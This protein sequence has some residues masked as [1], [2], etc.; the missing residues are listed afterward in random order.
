MISTYSN[1]QSLVLWQREHTYMYIVYTCTHSLQARYGDNYHWF[2]TLESLPTVTTNL[3]LWYPYFGQYPSPHLL[4]YHILPLHRLLQ[5][6]KKKFRDFNKNQRVA[7]VKMVSMYA[8]SKEG[9][10]L[11]CC[12]LYQIKINIVALFIPHQR[13]KVNTCSR[14]LQLHFLDLR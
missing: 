9:S 5:K 13:K 2:V 10:V 11:F 8:T 12:I 4:Q 1:F 6:E 7:L 3:C 14:V